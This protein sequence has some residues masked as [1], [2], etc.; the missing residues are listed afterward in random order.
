MNA[1][2]IVHSKIIHCNYI[3]TL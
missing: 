3:R 1:F 2:D